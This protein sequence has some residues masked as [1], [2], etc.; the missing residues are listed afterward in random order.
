MGKLL[1][2]KND[3]IEA[4]F[5]YELFELNYF[6]EIRFADLCEDITYVLSKEMAPSANYKVLVWIISC[7][8]RSV[9]S[10]LHKSDRYKI[11]NFDAEISEKWN[12]DYLEKLRALLADIVNVLLEYGAIKD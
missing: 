9:F 3:E 7:T 6:D 4:T 10:H 11:K 2:N 12:D 8:F 1:D 5:C